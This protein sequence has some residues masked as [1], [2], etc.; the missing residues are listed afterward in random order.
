[1]NGTM[2]SPLL[3]CMT[4]STLQGFQATTSL[5]KFQISLVTRPL[6]GTCLLLGIMFMIHQLKENE[7]HFSS[8]SLCQE[9]VVHE[10]PVP[11]R[12]REWRR[13]GSK[14]P[15]FLSLGF[16]IKGFII[17]LYK[18]LEQSLQ[19]MAFGWHLGYKNLILVYN[20]CACH[21]ACG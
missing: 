14:W 4:P 16:T 2:S 20:S 3:S 21:W 10:C 7:V 18:W 13:P 11:V 17:W 19:C 15:Y 8:Y 1:M 6:A 5:G 9:P 12:K